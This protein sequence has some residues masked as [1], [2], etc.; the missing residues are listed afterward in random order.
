[1][2]AKRIILMYISAVSGHRSAAIAIEKA[3][4]LLSPDTQILSINAFNYTNP[5]S[6]R[7]IN[8]LYMG[9]VEKAPAIWDYLYDN[10]Q[11]AKRIEKLKKAVHRFN[12][13]KLKKLFDEFR[14]DVVACTQAFPCG[15]VADFKKIYNSRIPLVA[16]LTDY[17]P[18]SY[19]IYDT[20]DFYIT[21]SDEVTGRLVSRGISGEKIKTLGIPFSPSFNQPIDKKSVLQ[22]LGL[23]EN[24]PTILIMGG[25]H[26]LGPIKTIIGSLE[27]TAQEIQEIIVAGANRRLY[28]SLA[29]QI[30][31]YKKKIAL[32]GFV[33]NI[34][35]LM[36]VS[37]IILTKP[38]GITVAEALGKKLPMLI[39]K[40]LPG[41]EASNTAYLT[42]KKAALKIDDLNRINLIIDD[43]LL[44]RD[45]LSVLREASGQI[46]KPFASRDIAELLLSLNNV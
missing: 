22:K 34:N 46:S 1:M 15:M 45:K 30:K 29:R 35:E 12:S 18:H 28:R 43:L 32:L 16:V 11:V 27:K 33:D 31:K 3:I 24:I 39:I 26:G 17:I 23:G 25:S 19:W 7:I 13:P 36:S 40:P 10:P 2:E 6:E 14:P 5:I 41:Q 37:D 8:R 9:V 4:K 21:P 20:V 42:E 38:G 44:D